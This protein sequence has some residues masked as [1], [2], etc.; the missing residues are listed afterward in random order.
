MMEESFHQE[1]KIIINIYALNNRAKKNEANPNRIEGR[2]SWR[3]NTPLS[4]MDR[5]T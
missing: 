4:I 5:T 2:N 1:Y 3:L